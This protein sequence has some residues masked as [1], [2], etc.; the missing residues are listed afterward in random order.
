MEH[1]LIILILFMGLEGIRI[2]KYKKIKLCLPIIVTF[3]FTFYCFLSNFWAINPQLTI[4]QSKTLFLVSSF[5]LVTYNF[6]IDIEK[7]EEYILKSIMLNS[8]S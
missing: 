5:L 4:N 2:I 7:G 3:L 1:R 6:F 8:D